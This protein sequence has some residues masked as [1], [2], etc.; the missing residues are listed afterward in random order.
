MQ[1]GNKVMLFE[2]RR[3]GLLFCLTVLAFAGCG[4]KGMGPQPV[5]KPIRA[6]PAVDPS[7]T[8]EKQTPLETPTERS[9]AS[10]PSQQPEA[11]TEPSSPGS[12]L[13]PGVLYADSFSDVEGAIKIKVD[14]DQRS[15]G[16]PAK[17]L[18]FFFS[19]KEI[20]GTL[21]QQAVEDNV[22][23][24]PD[25]RPGVLA[26]SWQE[27][28]AKLAYSGFTYLGEAA[29]RMAL[30]RLQQ[31]RTVDDLKNLRVSF[32]FKG[33]N[34]NSDTPLL[35]KVGCRL[36][37]VVPD[38]FNKRIDL[39]VFIASSE[40]GVHEVELSEGTNLEAFL[41]TVAEEAPTSFKLVWAQVGGI[42]GYHA[43]DTLLLDDIE[44]RDT[45]Q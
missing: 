37:P 36:E 7:G 30:P 44:I 41:K 40:W 15:V 12:E 10:E 8:A 38:S 4:R 6:K 2:R 16:P 1:Q 11:A 23:L 14:G 9:G 24:G 17:R 32:R 34:N 13:P 22:T 3:C 31:A 19:P 21:A 26:L 5:M 33:V 43:G 45:P 25:D 28:P 27:V 29:S 18:V 20:E 39:G 35:L 42:E